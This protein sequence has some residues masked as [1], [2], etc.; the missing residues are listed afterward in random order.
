MK[1]HSY[2]GPG[3]VV[4]IKIPITIKMAESTWFLVLWTVGFVLWSAYYLYMAPTTV[5]LSR[6]LS[7]NHKHLEKE[8][9]VC[10]VHN[11]GVP[12]ESCSSL[13][14]HDEQARETIH[15]S[16]EVKCYSCH[17]EHNE[18]ELIQASIENQVCDECHQQLKLDPESIFHPDRV[19]TRKVTY[20]PRKIFRHKP[21][22]FPPNYKCWQC[23][24]T[25][26]KTLDVPMKDLFKMDACLKCHERI[27][28]RVCHQY[29]QER[30]SRPRD[31]TCIKE[32][33]VPQLL[34]KTYGCTPYRGRAPGFIGLSVCET[35][36]P[37]ETYGQKHEPPENEGGQVEEVQND[38]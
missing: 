14:C 23:H 16:R 3:G 36:E 9:I 4:E 37:A 17:P 29:H 2:I 7:S 31:K 6:A 19:A 33:L 18:G 26:K 27:T 35:G 38:R 22:Q 21:H 20:V 24:C 1:K 15:N 12:N 11:E 13:D 8:C 25:G 10:H 30:V 28:C 32:E 34:L 5:F